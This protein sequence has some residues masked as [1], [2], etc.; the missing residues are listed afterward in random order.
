[1][2]IN[3]MISA[4]RNS[5]IEQ[6]IKEDIIGCINQMRTEIESIDNPYEKIVK[7]HNDYWSRYR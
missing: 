6:D 1:M 7:E 4:I 3:D 5:D 2:E